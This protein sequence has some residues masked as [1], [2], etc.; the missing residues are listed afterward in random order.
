M[1]LN[2]LD[3]SYSFGICHILTLIEGIVYGLD[4]VKVILIKLEG[5]L[6]DFGQI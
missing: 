1:I 6:L 2:L 5:I 4:E 3:Q